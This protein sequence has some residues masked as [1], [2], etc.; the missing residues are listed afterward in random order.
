MQRLDR[1]TPIGQIFIAT[2]FLALGIEHFIF[3]EFVTGRAPPWPASIP[4]GVIWAYVSGATIA[5]AGIAMLARRHARYAAILVGTLILVWALLRHLPVIATDSLLA[6]SWTRAGKALAFFGGALAL[7]ATLPH[8]RS[9][10]SRL[11][12]FVNSRREFIVLGRICLGTFLIIGG[13]QHF[14]YTPFVASLI[15]T[16]FP[17]D[18]TFWTYFAA[19]ALILG[20]VGLYIPWTAPL[21]AVLSGLMVFSWFWIVH[22]PR[23]FVSVS[24][25]IAVFEALGMSG[26]AFLLAGAHHRQSKTDPT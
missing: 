4:G 2:A 7:A 8:E 23:T 15:P 19:V 17:G 5:V 22:V 12:R 18:P 25:G 26:I 1:L 24:D 6:P 21:A 14:M 3:R 20:G 11:S 9:R 13:I 10:D 16:W